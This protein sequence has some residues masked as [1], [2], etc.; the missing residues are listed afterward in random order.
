MAALLDIANLTRRFGGVTAVNA[1]SLSVNEGEFVSVIGP[2]GAGKTTLFN[3][4]TGLDRPDAGTVTFGG[5]DIT[6]LSAEDLAPLG[7][8]RTFQHGRVFGNLSVLDNV[9]IGAHT[10]L[11]AVRPHLPLF[12][13]VAE[14]ALA[15]VRPASVKA[16]EEKLRADALDIIAL[17]GERLTPR[18]NNPAFSLSYANRRRLEIARA[19][20][21]KPRVLFLDEPTA[22]M[23]PSET[24][25]M[26]EI[27]RT[28]K[29]K[30]T[31]LLI[32]HKLDLVMQLSDRVT[33]M[34]DGKKIAEGLPKDVAADPAVITAY[35][36]ARE[37]GG[38]A[39]ATQE[40]AL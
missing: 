30:F 9:L 34:D 4:V 40:V 25:E 24:N 29:R 21:L 7:F 3:L 36:G 35:L 18:I 28:L 26:L 15:L 23:N 14:I 13:P 33:V 16:E 10:R 22:G 5:R 27:I 1:M 19:L 17:F 6:G 37:V 2:N 11:S 12:G 20:S 38:A 39:A 31:I 32:E 8:A